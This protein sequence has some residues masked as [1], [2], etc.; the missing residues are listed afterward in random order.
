MRSSHAVSSVV[1]NY[2]L[3]FPAYDYFDSPS[4]W[5]IRINPASYFSSGGGRNFFLEE[6]S[7]SLSAG[8]GGM[9]S[10]LVAAGGGK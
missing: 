4:I 7:G 2:G 8:R 9:R 6:G 10:K 5:L 3:P 1:P